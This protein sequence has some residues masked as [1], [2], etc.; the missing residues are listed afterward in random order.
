MSEHVFAVPTELFVEKIHTNDNFI[1]I[2]FT[3]FIEVLEYGDFF[4]RNKIED[5]TSFKQIIP[6]IVFKN[7]NTKQ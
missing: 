2:N 7:K 5:D 6:Y 3:Q 1:K 4:E